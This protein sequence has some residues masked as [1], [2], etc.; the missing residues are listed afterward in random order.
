MALPPA[1]AGQRDHVAGCGACQRRGWRFDRLAA[2]LDDAR[3]MQFGIFDHVE[4]RTD[5]ALAQQY[6]ERLQY[7][8]ACED[9]GFLCYHVAEHH[10]SLLCLA[11]NQA[12]YL[13]AVA[14][15]TRRIRLSA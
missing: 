3:T 7:V 15:H 1:P 11:P 5:V 9:A 2:R 12:V 10:N 13:A 6:E 4:R 8:R 14:Q